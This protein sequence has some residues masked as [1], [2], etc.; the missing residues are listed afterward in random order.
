MVWLTRL[1]NKT[2]LYNNDVAYQKTSWVLNKQNIKYTIKHSNL[3]PCYNYYL[4]LKNEQL[5]CTP[6]PSY[7]NIA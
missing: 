7:L 1:K 2:K 3:V 4:E 6:S 5:L